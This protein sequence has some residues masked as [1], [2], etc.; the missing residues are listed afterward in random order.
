MQE[1]QKGDTRKQK[2]AVIKEDE[3]KRKRQYEDYDLGIEEGDRIAKYEPETVRKALN[4]RDFIKGFTDVFLKGSKKG[5][6]NTLLYNTAS[7]LLIYFASWVIVHYFYNQ[8][9]NYCENRVIVS[10]P[11]RPSE[12]FLGLNLREKEC[13]AIFVLKENWDGY[14]KAAH[15]TE[16]NLLKLLTF[17]LGFYVKRMMARW[18]DQVSSIPTMEP[19]CLAMNGMGTAIDDKGGDDGLNKFKTRIARYI[20]LSWTMCLSGM[21]RPLNSNLKDKDSMIEK[22]LITKQEWESLTTMGGS[23]DGWKDK[24]WIPLSWATKLVNN[25]EK[26]GKKQ[27]T[28][29]KYIMS[30]ISKFGQKLQ[31]V[32]LYADNPMPRIQGQAVTIAAWSLL[33]VGVLAGQG[34]NFSEDT[35]GNASHNVIKFLTNLPLINFVIYILMFAWIKVGEKLSNP[36]GS[37]YQIDIDTVSRLDY[38]IWMASH[39]IQKKSLLPDQNIK[40]MV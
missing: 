6:Q 25:D 24:W 15:D 2:L 19:I 14:I 30:E 18:W 29:H 37:D 16:K 35:P 28:D 8:Q 40:L 11:T 17:L 12:S 5:V 38:E 33:I 21:S 4:D 7:I 3:I 39:L 32:S 36:F 1:K 31:H 26:N 22:G 13:A 34:K 10:S 20:I 23:R 27:F 9:L